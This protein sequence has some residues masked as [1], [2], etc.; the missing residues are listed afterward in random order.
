MSAKKYL[1]SRLPNIPANISEELA[2][3]TLKHPCYSSEAHNYARIHLPIAPAC[4]IKCN[5]CNRKFDCVNES[6]PGVSSKILTPFEALKLYKETKEK[7]NKLSVVGIAGPGDALANYEKTVETLKLIREYDQKVTFCLSTNGLKLSQYIEELH[8][9]GVSH[10]TVTMNTIDEKIGAKIYDYVISDKG[11]ITGEEAAKYLIEKQLEGVSKAASLGII[12]K[13]NTVAIKEINHNHIPKVI[14]KVSE[15]GACL[16]N[17]IPLI[18]VKDTKFESLTP[19]VTDELTKLRKECDSFV[20]QMYH[21]K[22]CR[23]DAIGR[24]N[25]ECNHK[26]N[27]KLQNNKKTG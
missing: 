1:E 14:K 15:I 24:L 22:Q 3:K 12:V 20:T 16:S 11:K 9:V 5:Y 18:P 17:I 27:S 7:Y 21:C 4:N 10:I 8:S 6:R 19:I 2:C 25:E 23:A 13:V 26:C